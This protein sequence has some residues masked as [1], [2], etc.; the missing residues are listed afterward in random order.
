MVGRVLGSSDTSI[1]LR[2]E[3]CPR[4]ITYTYPA[5]RPP[6]LTLAWPGTRL[7]LDADGLD[8]SDAVRFAERLATATAVWAD[9]VR[10]W[11]RHRAETRVGA[12]PTLPPLPPPADGHESAGGAAGW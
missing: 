12:F 7:G 3:A 9:E 8:D 5:S 2:P 11:V 10:E 6:V 1:H 4:V